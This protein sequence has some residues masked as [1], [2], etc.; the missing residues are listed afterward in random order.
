M[1]VNETAR[2]VGSELPER[3]LDLA[4]GNIEIGHLCHIELYRVLAVLPANWDHLGNARDGEEAWAHDPVDDLP[5]LHRAGLI[6]GNGDQHD[7]AHNRCDGR[8]LRVSVSR[9]LLAHDAQTF[10]DLLTIEI[11]LRSPVELDVENR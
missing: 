2:R 10:C 9:Q 1:L 6:A 4:A 11:D 8:H 7:F 3:G 5:H